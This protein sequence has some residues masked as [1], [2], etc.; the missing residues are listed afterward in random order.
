MEAVVNVLEKEDTMSNII[1]LYLVQQTFDSND[2]AQLILRRRRKNITKHYVSSNEFSLFPTI[3]RLSPNF[4]KNIPH[5]FHVCRLNI[6]TR[7]L[8]FKHLH[9]ATHNSTTCSKTQDMNY[10][11]SIFFSLSKNEI[12]CSASSKKKEARKNK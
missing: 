3:F 1:S 8:M 9:C 12:L 10:A 4:M 7:K 2:G 11:F 5:K 6:A